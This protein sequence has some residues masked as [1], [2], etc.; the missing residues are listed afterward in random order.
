MAD[1]DEN[2]AIEREA[3]SCADYIS[4][5]DRRVIREAS[6]R[7]RQRWNSERALERIGGIDRAYVMRDVR[8]RRRVLRLKRMAVAVG[9][10]LIF[11]TWLVCLA[12]MSGAIFWRLFG[13]E[14]A[15]AIR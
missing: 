1:P 9:R 3:V 14:I 8:R 4:G 7:A 11:W 5:H 13:G 10:G 12:V 6:A 2:A 15:R